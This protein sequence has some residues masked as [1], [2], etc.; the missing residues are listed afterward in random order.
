MPLSIGENEILVGLG[1]GPV[2]QRLDRSNRHGVVAGALACACL[3]PY[4]NVVGASGGVYCMHGVHVANL[5]LNWAEMSLGVATNHWARLAFV[6]FFLAYEG[7]RYALALASLDRPEAL[8]VG[9]ALAR[10]RDI[11]QRWPR[12]VERPRRRRHRRRCRVARRFGHGRGLCLVGPRPR[13]RERQREL[14]GTAA[15][16]LVR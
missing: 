9:A 14:G 8:E 10:A 4:S 6:A 15:P 2:T 3:D 16:Q 1:E 12:Q 11:A 7:A 5:V 13:G